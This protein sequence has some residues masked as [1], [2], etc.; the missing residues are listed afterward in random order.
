MRRVGITLPVL[1]LLTA[2]PV[3]AQN[4]PVERPAP[5]PR[6]QRF[7]VEEALRLRTTLQLTEQQIT[8]LETLRRERVEA[9]AARMRD[10]MD[11][12]SRLRAGTISREEFRNEVAARRDAQRARLAERGNPVADIL[13]DRQR[14]QLT[15]LRHDAMQ[16]RFGLEMRHHGWQGRGGF[17]P[18]MG[19]P[20]RPFGGRGFGTPGV[21]GWRPPFNR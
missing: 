16:R 20:R 6:V 12:R 7:G 5:H 18:R 4:P 13:T 11:L 2:L 15:E 14:Q 9:Q 21:R 17:G 3:V 19:L 10:L 8:R 1:G